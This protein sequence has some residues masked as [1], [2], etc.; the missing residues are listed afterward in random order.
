MTEVAGMLEKKEH[1]E[2]EV[3]KININFSIHS[4]TFHVSP[5]HKN[6]L[7][8]CYVGKSCC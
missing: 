7:R 5:I 6:Y 2:N 3:R 1:E 8:Y 4:H